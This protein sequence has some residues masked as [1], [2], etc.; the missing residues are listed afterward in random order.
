MRLPAGLPFQRCPRVVAYALLAASVATMLLAA[1]GAYRWYHDAGTQVAEPSVP[2]PS[3]P[4][5]SVQAPEPAAAETRHADSPPQT[6][7][8][9]AKREVVGVAEQPE[10]QPDVVPLSNPAAGS[11]P[12]P[13]A[14]PNTGTAAARAPDE[15]RRSEPRRTEPKSSQQ[16]KTQQGRR[17]PAKQATSDRAAPRRPVQAAR[18]PAPAANP[19][20]YYER[21]SQLGFAP[22]LRKR[23]CNPATGQMPMQCYY[24]R[25]G[26]E[27]FPAKP[28][29]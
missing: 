27:R 9:A 11:I 21:D 28:L 15:T 14:A 4:E 26:R 24:P 6:Q 3:V 12:N 16:A 29:D 23:T 20:V 5:R 13:A 10:T 8:A 18:P 19:N 17:S 2:E 25:E 22:Q 1:D 7:G